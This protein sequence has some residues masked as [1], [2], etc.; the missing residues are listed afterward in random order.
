MR[1]TES[2]TNLTKRNQH[3]R[4]CIGRSL[5][6]LMKEKQLESITIT[7]LV[8]HANVS[9]MTFYKYYKTKLEVLS[10]FMYELVHEYMKDANEKNNIGQFGEYK[11]IKHCFE[12]FK[13]YHC[14]VS[15]LI[16]ANMYSV[17]INALNDYMDQYVLKNS[18]RS[19]YEL[20]YYAGALCN[21][22][23]KWIEGGMKETPEQIAHIVYRKEA[24]L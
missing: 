5:L 23:V 21:I 13:E 11:H 14:F 9:R 1:K 2:G 8:N 15:I 3:I 10:D 16:G 22:Y 20:Y 7:E 19:R 6:I 4:E 17:I 24:V 18:N 12:F